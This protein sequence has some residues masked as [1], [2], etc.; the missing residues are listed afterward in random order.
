MG[1]LPHGETSRNA[2]DPSRGDLIHFQPRPIMGPTKRST[3]SGFCHARDFQ[4]ISC[5]LW[6]STGRKYRLGHPTREAHPWTR[7]DTFQGAFVSAIQ[8]VPNLTRYVP[9]LKSNSLVW[10]KEQACLSLT[11]HS[12]TAQKTGVL[13]QASLIPSAGYERTVCL[14]A[15]RSYHH[16]ITCHFLLAR[17]IVLAS[18]LLSWSEL[19]IA[20]S[21]V[22]PS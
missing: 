8:Y 13:M 4:A 19:I 1:S 11:I 10:Q 3:I 20:H 5:V 22:S 16:P 17:I 6:Y 9:N 12:T 21:V 14:R 7:W 2:S 15:P 18:G